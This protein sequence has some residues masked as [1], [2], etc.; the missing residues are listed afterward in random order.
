MGVLTQFLH[1]KNINLKVIEIDV[2]SIFYL[3]LNY[4]E[5]N[6]IEGDFL[7]INLEEV[8]QK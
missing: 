1:N 2:E 6:I 4:P 5:L 3:R 8:Y 7:K